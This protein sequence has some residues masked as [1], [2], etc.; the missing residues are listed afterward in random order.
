MVD[1]VPVLFVLLF[2]V[3]GSLLYLAV[4]LSFCCIREVIYVVACAMVFSRIMVMC[5]GLFLIN[6]NSAYIKAISVRYR[7]F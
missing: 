7:V 1:D 3:L 2:L 4:E 6:V 5:L